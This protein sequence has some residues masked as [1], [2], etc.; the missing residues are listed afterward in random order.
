MER[1]LYPAVFRRNYLIL[2]FYQ[3]PEIMVPVKRL[4]RSRVAFRP[5]RRKLPRSWPTTDDSLSSGCSSA[6]RTYRNTPAG[7]SSPGRW[8]LGTEPPP[9]SA[10]RPLPPPHSW[11]LL[12]S[13]RR[14]WCFSLIRH[15]L[16]GA[17]RS[18]QRAGRACSRHRGLVC[19]SP[20]QNLKG[21]ES[22]LEVALAAEERTVELHLG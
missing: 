21:F 7:R 13:E 8:S 10:L 1:T 3:G 15:P 11:S 2:C 6:P 5:P 17:L 18:A 12:Q 14:R 4:L 9:T 19:D 20:L 22:R 16:G